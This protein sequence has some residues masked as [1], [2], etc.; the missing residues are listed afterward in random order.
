MRKNEKPPD[1]TRET[2]GA[3]EIL[4]ARSARAMV[5]DCRDKKRYRKNEIFEQGTLHARRWQH[6]NNW[7]EPFERSKIKDLWLPSRLS[8]KLKSVLRSRK[9]SSEGGSQIA[10][11]R[12]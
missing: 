7:T 8:K 6:K 9:D 4:E 1:S 3:E 11:N 5:G 12:V 2:I 10:Q